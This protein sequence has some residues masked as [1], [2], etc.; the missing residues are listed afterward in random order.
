LFREA[1]CARV[2]DAFQPRRDID[3]VAHKIAVPLLG[4]VADMNSDAT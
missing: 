3:P 2:R 4:Q 1:D